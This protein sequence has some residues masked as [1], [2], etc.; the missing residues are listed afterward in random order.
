MT[1]YKKLVREA[2]L[3]ILEMIYNAQTS[4]IGSNYSCV[5]ILAVLFEQMDLEK[6]KLIVSKG[7]VAA[8][9]Y[10]F[11]AEK[12]IIPKEDL[13]RYCAQDEKEYIGLIEPMGKFGLEFAGGSMGYGLPAG[14]GYAMSKKVK[15]EEG[16]VYV[17]MSDGELA[18]G[19]TWE[20][21]LIA[22]HQNLNNLNVIVDHN[23]LQAM[24]SV[25]QILKLHPLKDKWLAFNWHYEEMNGHDH[26]EMEKKL[27][28][29]LRDR[30]SIFVANTTKGKG[31]D[32]MHHDN[33]WHYKS[34]SEEEYLK[35]KIQL[36]S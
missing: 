32:F 17:L 13:K 35:A 20:S 23:L 24:G 33:I 8:S 6:D 16:N 2:R 11:L 12:G 5:D 9:V 1:D 26:E 7:W 29:E 18:I 34:P 15:K 19:T 10:W 3:G 4:H 30:P 27:K 21:A 28:P 14:V 25:H 31:V 22:A 36:E